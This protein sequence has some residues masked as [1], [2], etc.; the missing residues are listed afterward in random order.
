MES[1][2]AVSLATN[3]ERPLIEDIFE[4]A[5]AVQY[6]SSFDKIMFVKSSSVVL[7]G[8]PELFCQFDELL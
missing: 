8:F 2:L 4:D 3:L 5:Q 7:Q 6:C 1:P